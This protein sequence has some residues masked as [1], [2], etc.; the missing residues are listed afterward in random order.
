MKTK[1]SLCLIACLLCLA[2]I[3]GACGS[4]E[5]KPKASDF[6]MTSLE[7]LYVE[8]IARRAS[9]LLTARD[10]QTAWIV[11]DWPDSA[12]VSYHWELTGRYDAETGEIAYSDAV[13]IEKTFNAQG[14]ESDI[15]LYTHGTGSF[16]KE[17]DKLLW[18]D[19]EETGSGK[20][21]FLYEMSLE[22]YRNNQWAP[23]QPEVS[24]L[25]V[26][27][28]VEPEEEPEPEP[29]PTP[30][31]ANLP[32]ITKSPTDET[33]AEGGNASF[34]ARYENALWAVWHFVS[35]DGT[36]DIT[37]EEASEVFP[38]LEIINGMYST[39]KLRNIP[40]ELSGWR[41]YCRYSNPSGYKDTGSALITVTNAP[42]P[43]PTPPPLGPVVNDWTETDDLAVAEGGSGMYF[44][45][46]A[47]DAFPEGLHLKNYRYRSGILEANYAN[48]ADEVL[49]TIRKSTTQSGTELSGDYNSY[50]NVWNLTLN[51]VTLRCMGD[52]ATINTGT[53]DT[54]A[55]HF[56]ICYNP[57]Q[58]G[59]GLTVAQLSSMVS[60]MQ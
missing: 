45:L 25:P 49:L 43:T 3:L 40:V 2:L 34:V 36:T 7:G 18:T 20:S 55:E 9:L 51:G 4:S 27:E 46:P 47:S 16:A 24:A 57:G 10:E 1:R 54:A 32:I 33:V 15:V 11:V 13:L 52:G 8:Q 53:Y 60:G 31:P 42:T 29:E 48:D 26:E 12:A 23:A 17:L 6:N 28:P 5:P 37:Y 39:M 21:A 56:S 50:S 19:N 14:E 30:E 35:P 59:Q 22:A 41:V 38:S 44:T 58:P